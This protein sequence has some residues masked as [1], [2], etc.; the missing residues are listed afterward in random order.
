MKEILERL[1][2]HEILSR[3]ECADT[4]KGITEGKFN[5][6]R[7]AAF[8]TAFR[9]RGIRSE[10]LNGF[11]D[12]LMELCIKV[13]VRGMPSIDVCGTG[14]DGK[15]TFNIS[16]LSALVVAGAGHKVVKHGNKSVSS[17]CGSSDVLQSLGYEFTNNEDELLD[18]LDRTNLCFLHAPLFHPA[19]KSVGS[20]RK[21]LGIKTFFNMLGPLV[22][23][24]SPSHQMVG[25]FSL[26][27]MRLY[28]EIFDDL[29]HK[30]AIVHGLNGF[31]EISLTDETK[32]V[33]SNN[34]TYLFRSGDL[35]LPVY[36]LDDLYGGS[37][38]DESREIL[39]NVLNNEASEAQ[40]NVVLANSAL[41]IDCFNEEPDLEGSFAAAKESLES[42]RALSVLKSLM[43]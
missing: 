40:T 12:A 29:G 20:I 43:K 24:C 33:S 27:L 18:Q 41:A 42:G 19:L 23:P 16:T 8:M 37:T 38:V 36:Q 14:G 26:K 15:N 25:V 32:V 7:I 11:R 1:T 3:S 13:D 10:E 22:N 9:M 35:G 17:K 6:A 34:G 4:L 30:Y 28:H 2:N 5:D 39:L 21:N 31:D